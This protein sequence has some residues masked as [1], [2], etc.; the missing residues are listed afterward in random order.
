MLTAHAAKCGSSNP[1]A[2][3]GTVWA[4]ALLAVALIVS[5]GF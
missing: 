3:L 4:L 1:I 2:F 5:K